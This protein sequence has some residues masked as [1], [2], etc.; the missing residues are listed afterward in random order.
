MNRLCNQFEASGF[1][2]GQV[3]DVVDQPQQ[4]FTTLV[5]VI[6]VAALSCVQGTVALVGD[7]FGEP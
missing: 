3:K 1:D 5:D 2:L 7:Q 6:G 4:V